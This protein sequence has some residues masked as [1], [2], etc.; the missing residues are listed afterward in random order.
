M[1]E[2]E[3]YNNPEYNNPNSIFYKVKKKPVLKKDADT[4]ELYKVK[5][6]ED[7]NSKNTKFPYLGN[8]RE[9]FRKNGDSFFPGFICVD[10]FNKIP[11]EYI[12]EKGGKKYVKI[13]INKYINGVN[14]HGNTHSCAVDTYSFKKEE[15]VDRNSNNK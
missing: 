13:V 14:E 8:L 12:V 11:P 3:M 5:E 15:D 2:E 7:V 9:K 10:D 1:K 4:D 6:D